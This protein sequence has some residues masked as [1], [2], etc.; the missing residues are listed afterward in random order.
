MERLGCLILILAIFL[1]A[2]LPT[3]FPSTMGSALGKL[4]LPPDVALLLFAAMFVGSAIEV[5]LRRISVEKFLRVDPL[6]PLGLSGAL[7]RLEKRARRATVALNVG[8]GLIPLAIAAYEVS[9]I[10]TGA[11]WEGRIPDGVDPP[12]VPGVLVAAILA[13]AANAAA[14]YKLARA[15]PGVGIVVPGI[16]PPIVA[17]AA[18]LLLSA[19]AAAPVMF[20]A[21]VAGT[22]AAAALR[23]R[24]FRARPIGLASLGGGGHF[25]AIVLVAVL[26]AY[27]A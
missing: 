5:P 15:V 10:A 24:G 18:S 14:S 12:N 26:S 20:V 1:A 25:D 21:G 19:D 27:L 6:A 3:A 8:G 23:L 22:L 7:P 17:M 13:T 11:A 4:G 16:I 9:R 2:L